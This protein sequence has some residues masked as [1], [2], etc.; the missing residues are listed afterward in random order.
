[1]NDRVS[2]QEA[3]GI[4]AHE[5]V[6]KNLPAMLGE[7][8]F[9]ALTKAAERSQDADVAKARARVPQDTPAAH[10]GEETLGYLAEQNPNHPLVQ[11]AVDAV[12][13]ML[14][15]AGIPLNKLNAEG[16]ALRKI[17]ALNLKHA[18]ET[19]PDGTHLV[20]EGGQLRNKP[21]IKAPLSV[22]G[23]QLGKDT[24]TG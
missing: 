24:Q 18:A 6:H 23:D 13:L 3:P 10:R 2:D 12:K 1:M 15:K 21:R 20:D 4:L 14:N 19:A 11:R 5:V 22:W 7:P 9:Q 8:R 16:A 17:I